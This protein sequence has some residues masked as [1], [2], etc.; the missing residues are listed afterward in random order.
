MQNGSAIP[1]WQELNR[2]TMAM[3]PLCHHNKYYACRVLLV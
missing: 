1:A 2:N 3:P